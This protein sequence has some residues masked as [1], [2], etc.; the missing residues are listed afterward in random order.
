M[1]IPGKNSGNSGMV[2]FPDINQTTSPYSMLQH[3][4]RVATPKLVPRNVID[5][6][7]GELM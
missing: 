1:S 5:N 3:I 7:G 2:L 6:G 4:G